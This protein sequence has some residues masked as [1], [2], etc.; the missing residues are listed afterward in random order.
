VSKFD[1]IKDII[2]EKIHLEIPVED[3][4]GNKI[5]FLK[6]ITKNCIEADNSVINKLTE[7][8]NKASRHFLSSFH[9]TEERTKIWLSN[10]VLNKTNKLLFLIYPDSNFAGHLGF[11][12]LNDDS[13]E[14]DNLIR[15]ES[16]G[17]PELILFT[18]FAIMDWLFTNL[19]ISYVHARVLYRNIMAMLIHKKVGFEINNKIYLKEIVEENET[20]F[21][22]AADKEINEKIFEYII[23]INKEKFYQIYNGLKNGIN[24]SER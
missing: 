9:A 14:L 8:R 20:R 7:W 21:I 17:H 13:A 18:E 6:P 15:G 4:N 12:N 3:F 22:E 11:T 16:T 10:Q 19:D 1:F 23:S 5:G 2:E 24:S